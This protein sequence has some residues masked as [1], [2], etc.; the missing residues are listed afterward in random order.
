MPE[1]KQA[2]RTGNK[3]RQREKKKRDSLSVQDQIRK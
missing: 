1:V 2:N 3:E